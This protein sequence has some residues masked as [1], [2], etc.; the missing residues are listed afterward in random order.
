[1]GI[2]TKW[3][4]WPWHEWTG[5]LLQPIKPL[6]QFA[7]SLLSET[8]SD[9]AGEI[10][11]RF[12]SQKTDEQGADTFS[13]GSGKRQKNS[14]SSQPLGGSRTLPSTGFFCS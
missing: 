3:T 2:S 6:S 9:F 5:L 7:L 10:R 8:G 4:R 14:A 11:L 13:R 1:M 12:L